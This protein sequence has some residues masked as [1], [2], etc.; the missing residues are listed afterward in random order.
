MKRTVIILG[1][2]LILLANIIMVYFAPFGISPLEGFQN[3]V[4]AATNA[5][6]NAGVN[7]G[8][9]NAAAAPPAVNAAAPANSAPA[10]NAAPVM[11]AVPGMNNGAAPGPT[12]PTQ[13]S[14]V[15]GMPA[16]S[17]GAEGFA[18]FSPDMAGGAKDMYQ[19]IGAFDGV[20]LSTG[21][22]LSS[23]RY[24][25]PNESLMGPEF[26]PGPDSLFMFKSNQCKPE[27]CGASFSCGGGC[28][29][30]TPGQRQYI[31]SRG[32]NRTAPE[33]SA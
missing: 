10:V 14:T 24:T 7:A 11:N 5:G 21:N 3:A 22:S 6:A 29:C 4:A 17:A 13:E 20:K 27:C 30:T 15:P 26:E 32:G 28:V 2:A 16:N 9:A 19:P 8:A 23:W 18:S 12:M 1:L 33:D 25:A 31:A